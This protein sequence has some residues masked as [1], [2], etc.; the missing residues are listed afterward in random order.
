MSSLD[1]YLNEKPQND[2]SDVDEN[3][4]EN[5]ENE[6]DMDQDDETNEGDDEEEEGE[7]DE[8]DDEEDENENDNDEGDEDEEGE[9]DYDDD[10]EE[11][12]NN[13][14]ENK[15]KYGFNIDDNIS[16]RRYKKTN[17]HNDL[18]HQYINENHP[19]L[20]ETPFEEMNVLTKIVRNKAGNIIDKLHRSPP[21][22]TKFERAKVIGIRT[23]QLNNGSLPFIDIEE[24]LHIRNDAIAEMELNSKK[25]P[26]I[27]SRPIPGGRCEYW[28]L[29][30]L[31][32]V[33]L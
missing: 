23:N 13:K 21:F 4:N 33:D 27:I 16:A 5:N 20:K 10:D 2:D 14:K 28:K 17:F 12:E 32:I 22:L 3:E 6:T 24:S 29:S 9:E 26:F 18:R 15:N 31:E 25:L 1:T 7:G 11:D 19:E 8:D 30:D